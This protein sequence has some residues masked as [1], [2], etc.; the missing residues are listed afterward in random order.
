MGK[1][2]SMGTLGS[3]RLIPIKKNKM[4]KNSKLKINQDVIDLMTA[5]ERWGR[6]NFHRAIN[7]SF[8]EKETPQ[9]NLVAWVY[10][11]DCMEDFIGSD[12][13]HITHQFKK[14]IAEIIYDITASILLSELN[15]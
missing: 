7:K 10:G 4:S 11:P 9:H 12:P 5:H 15:S 14:W 13:H 3:I 1:L 2:G 6:F 8:D